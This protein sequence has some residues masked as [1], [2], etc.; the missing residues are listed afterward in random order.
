MV[1]F[2]HFEGQCFLEPEIAQKW[3]TT[4]EALQDF[5]QRQNE[6]FFPTTVADPPGPT[7]WK[8]PVSA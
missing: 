3:I 5:C 7:I 4:V 6:A 1:D 2:K 8:P